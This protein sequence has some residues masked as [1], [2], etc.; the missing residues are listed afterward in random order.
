MGNQ[1]PFR[2]DDE[3]SLEG[4]TPVEAVRASA[5]GR[6][7]CF[8]PWVVMV[9]V[10]LIAVLGAYAFY[11]NGQVNALKMAL[12]TASN[13]RDQLS[14]ALYATRSELGAMIA[15]RDMKTADL[16]ECK[17]SL[18]A[19]TAEQEATAAE[20]AAAQASLAA[21]TAEQEATAA[22]LAAVQ[23]SLAA[24]TAEQEATAEELAAAQE[25]L[26][27]K[28]AEQEA[29]AAELAA[30][31][32]ALIAA[33]SELA[34]AHK[35]LEATSKQIDELNGQLNQVAAMLLNQGGNAEEDDALPTVD[36]AVV[37]GD[38]IT[39]GHYEQD[40]DPA[41]TEAIEWIVLDVKDGK[42]LVLSK[43]CLT[44]RTYHPTHDAVTWETSDMRA[45]L[46]AD[47]VQ[48]AFTEQELGAIAL[49]EVKACPYPGTMGFA[50]N[51]TMDRVFLLDVRDVNALLR[52]DEVRNA[53]ATPYA[54]EHGASV[55]T[56]NGLCWWW[57]RTPGEDH[58]QVAYISNSSI[59]NTV[60]Q[61]RV[62]DVD[63]TNTKHN[64]T[65]GVR[66]AMWIDLSVLA[67]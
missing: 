39:F 43:Y 59:A 42:A 36:D 48:A 12:E 5:G 25:L 55:S 41:D 17:A 57:L 28:T 44:G 22:E 64:V 32:E 62:G 65:G 1:V 21:K 23:A 27:A 11:L 53:H 49:T 58:T 31:Q 3:K 20:L 67:D 8:R 14:E 66:P 2:R 61:V 51:D 30:A 6:A 50:G 33:E 15:Q 45:W 16:E 19:R 18:A 52:T 60:G 34:E 56:V 47:F 9:A 24:R 35:Q 63:N 10:M 46:N 4:F 54:D 40:N 29:T 26:A 13:E 38:V 37:A 7:R